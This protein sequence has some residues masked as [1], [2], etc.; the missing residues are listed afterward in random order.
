VNIHEE[1]LPAH[2]AGNREAW[3]QFAADYV[4]NGEQAWSEDEVT[5]GIYSVPESEWHLLPDDLAG[6][7]AIELGCGTAYVSAWLAKRGAKPVGIDNSPKQ[8]ETARR[9]QKE[10]GIDFPLLLGNAE[11]VPYPDA[12]F[13]YAISEYGAAIW[14]DPYKWIPEAARL[15]RPGGELMFLQNSTISMLCTPD[16]E[17]EVPLENRLERPQFGLFSMSWEDHSTEFHLSHGEQLRLLRDSGFE[18]LDLIEIRPPADASTTYR[19]ASLDWARH[20]PIEE[21]W[22]ARKR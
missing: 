12:S 17:E 7:D 6:K 9:L 20:W 22:K 14:C 3:D 1:E 19:W 5:W 13:D 21:A 18:V 8:L 15:L 4:A 10:H 2:V 11:T 16:Q